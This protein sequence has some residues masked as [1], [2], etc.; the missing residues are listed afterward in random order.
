MPD[1]V[2]PV[3][4]G[5]DS[6]QVLEDVEVEFPEPALE[7]GKIEKRVEIDRCEVIPGKVIVVGRVVKNIPFKTQGSGH[8]RRPEGRRTRVI[9]GDL[10]HC[11]AFIPFKLFIEIPGAEEG[12]RCEVVEACVLGEVDT[13]V[14]ENG[15]GCFERLEETIDIHVRV[16]VIRDTVMNVCAARKPI[17][18][19]VRF[20]PDRHHKRCCCR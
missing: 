10:R 17:R 1:A 19:K 8:C 11:T 6:G 15:D 13:L 9:C 4:V 3:L 16:R 12:D 20:Q 14:D 2:L 7:V 5:E 18:R